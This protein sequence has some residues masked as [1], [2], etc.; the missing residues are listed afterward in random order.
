LALAFWLPI[1]FLLLL[2]PPPPP[3]PNESNDFIF[4]Y[5]LP[6]KCSAARTDIVVVEESIDR[7]S[8]WNSDRR[9]RQSLNR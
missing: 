2:L 5:C 1:V 4:F 9:R 6:N 7:F 3:P 8:V